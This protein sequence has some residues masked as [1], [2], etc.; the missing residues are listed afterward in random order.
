MVTFALNAEAARKADAPARIVQSGAYVGT[1]T[2]AELVTSDSGTQGVEF[3]FVG[4]D[5]SRAGYL[6]LWTTNSE[7]QELR[8]MKVL[9]AL[10]AC[11][12]LRSMDSAQGTVKVWDS[13]V[14]QEVQRA[15]ELLPALMGKRVGVVLQREEYWPNNGGDKKSRMVLFTVFQAGTNLMAKEIL[16]RIAKPEALAKLVATLKDKLAGDRPAPR[17]GGGYSGGGNGGNGGGQ[18]PRQQSGR[19]P[20][21]FDDMDDDTPF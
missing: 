7:G 17:N 10:M 15:A 14:G 1:F 12:Q 6:T 13:K 3:D 20:S 8:G 5:G 19:A 21:G 16:D 2:R 11:L 18:A 4:D 9:H